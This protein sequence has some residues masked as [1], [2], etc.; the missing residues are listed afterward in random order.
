MKGV[1][2]ACQCSVLC[3]LTWP[4]SYTQSGA[5][6]VTYRIR[7]L[8]M[9]PSSFRS[10]YLMA[11]GRSKAR[12]CSPEKPSPLIPP[13]SSTTL[14]FLFRHS[15]IEFST[16]PSLLAASSLE[17]LQFVGH[18]MQVACV[19]LISFPLL[20]EFQYPVLPGV[21]HPDSTS[22]LSYGV[23]RACVR[24]SFTI[25]SLGSFSTYTPRLKGASP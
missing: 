22:F 15:F 25:L 20:L 6:Y 24:A 10:V 7:S 14:I 1:P 16:V 8:R 11:Y 9:C 21:E 5:V 12:L 3:S 18:P 13:H 4:S 2:P 17:C 23:S 19:P